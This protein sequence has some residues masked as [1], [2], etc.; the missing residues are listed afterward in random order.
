MER[1][2]E[3]CT[4]CIRALLI[5]ITILM[6]EKVDWQTDRQTNNRTLLNGLWYG[7]GHSQCKNRIVL[8]ATLFVKTDEY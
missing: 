3:A 5:I 2:V 4:V 7:L 6:S 8:M 1:R